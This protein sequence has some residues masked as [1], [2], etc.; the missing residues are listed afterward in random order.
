VKSQYKDIITI[1][2]QSTTPLFS[3]LMYKAIIIYLIQSWLIQI[4]ALHAE[5][6]TQ[7]QLLRILRTEED[8]IPLTE[9]VITRL[10]AEDIHHVE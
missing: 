2:R 1:I 4:I 6:I 8:T 10:A 7:Q 9:E 5:D 3:Q